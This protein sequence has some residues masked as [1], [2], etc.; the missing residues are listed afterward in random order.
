MGLWQLSRN[1]WNIRLMNAPYGDGLKHL[2]AGIVTREELG[3]LIGFL[4]LVLKG[5]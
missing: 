3:E 4:S 2:K 5:S 1:S